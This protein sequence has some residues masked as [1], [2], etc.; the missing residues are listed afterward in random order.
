MKPHKGVDFSCTPR[1]RL[2]VHSPSM[3]ATPTT[4]LNDV[5]GYADF[6]GQQRAI[7]DAALS[8][9]DVLVLMPTG[10]GKSLCYQI[11]AMLRSGTGLV[12]SPLIA[13]MQDQVA[14]LMELGIEAAYLN[15]SQPW[16]EQQAVMHRLRRGEL[17]LLYVA[18][19]R[20]A[21]SGT[22]ALLREI[23]ISLIAI[24][25]AHCVSQW[26]HDFRH[27]YLSL[28]ELGELFPGVP[29]M[30]VTATATERTR[31]EIVD[32]LA[33]ADPAM[34]ISPF[35][36]PNISYA[37]HAKTDPKSQLLKFLQSHR[38]EAG[39]VYCLSRKKTESTAAWLNQQGFTALPYH[40]GLDADVRHDNQRRF[41]VEDGLIIVATIA[42]GMGIDKPDVR[43]VAHL[44]LPKS[45]ESYYQETGRAGRD[46]DPAEAWMAYGLQ[47]VVRLRQ[48]LDESDADDEY[49]RYEG[50][51]LDALLGWC[52]GTGCRR[53]PLLEYFGDTLADDCGNCDGC[54]VPAKTWDGTEA[55]QKLLSTA[56]RTGQRF[57]AAHLVDVL[58]GKETDK[59]RQ[60]GHDRL[61]V[62][63]IGTER[64]TSTWRSVVRQLIAAGHLRADAERF[65][66]LVLTETSRGVLRGETPIRFREDP[67]APVKAPRRSAAR[68]HV[69]AEEDRALW[70]AL[71]ACRQT[72]ADEHNVPAYVIFHDATLYEFLEQRPQTEADMLAISGVG[73]TK[74]ERYGE[75]FLAVLRDSTASAA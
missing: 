60:N 70:E 12:V 68:G 49:K 38:N 19:E 56:Y 24:D 32:R 29:R 27:D 63:G 54:L 21:T 25:E 53:R 3:H 50:Y 6:R 35:D 46:G 18:P 67:K 36:R 11:P 2:C 74:L 20:L 17:Q 55:A 37:V 26:G 75:G 4:L 72:F 13:L 9:Q 42:F 28:G 22:R 62:Y 45:M 58:L 1:L 15:S 14:A 16:E 30:A 44:D 52:E 59:I 69:V 64:S 61:S 48:M 43:F 71:R 7:I 34:F 23:P 10:G 5:F 73:Q 51:K 57:G 31:A 66:A 39:I 65:G 8:G 41:L 47:D 40:A 33:F